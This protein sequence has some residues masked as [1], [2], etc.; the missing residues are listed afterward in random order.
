MENHSH[1][2]DKHEHHHD[3][4]G[5]E[6]HNHAGHSHRE[7]HKQM[8]QD[9]KWRF[10]WV[11]L[12][13]IPILALSPMIQQFLGVDWRFAGD[14]WIL[15][16]L[17]TLVFFFGGGPFLTGLI[18]ELRKK[19]PGMMTLIGL[20]I[21]IAYFYSTAV[22]LGFEGDL[23]YWELSTLVGIMLLGHWV[24]MRSV[25][26]ASA[27]L[28]EL[29]ELLPN[30][31]HRVNDDG[32]TEDVPLDELRQGDKVL[33]KPGE[34]IPADGNVVKGNSSVNEA[35]LTGESKPV[36]KKE[37]D[38]VIGGS[39]NEKGSLTVEISKT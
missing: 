21:S 4:T 14:E 36:D 5:T 9:F 38:E 8:V 6:N 7:H 18:D 20:A 19:Q 15:A 11:L 23:L 35:M 26:S 37:G 22:V 27:A 30:E 34:K 33:V 2:H 10:W 29:A 28:E 25:L 1:G 13:T 39:V 32:S 31:A 16:G 17:S 24:E 3:H 12:I